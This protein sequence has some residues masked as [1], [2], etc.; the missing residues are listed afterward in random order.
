MRAGPARGLL[1]PSRA[2]ILLLATSLLLTALGGWAAARV[3][4]IY[5]KHHSF[6]FDPV[7]YQF[8]NA[9]LSRQ[10]AVDGRLATAWSEWLNNDR[11]PFRTVPLVLLA[12]KLLEEPLGYLATAL[13]ALAVFLALLGWFL[14]RRYGSP[15]YAAAGMVLF[16]SIPGLYDPHAGLGVYL[17][18]LPA[19]LWVG[20]ALICLLQWNGRSRLAWLAAFAGFASLAALSRYVAAGYLLVMAGPVLL[21]MLWRRWR[22]RGDLFQS[23]IKPLALVAAILGILAGYY[24]VAH[25]K[26]TMEFYATYGY[27]LDSEL[28]RSARATWRF[29]TSYLG[30]RYFVLLAL[31]F[32]A[33]VLCG[34]RDQ[35]GNRWLAALAWMALAHP[36]FLILVLGMGSHAQAA[37]YTLCPLFLLVLAPYPERERLSSPRVMALAAVAIILFSAWQGVS[38][39]RANMRQARVTTTLARQHKSMDR[40]LGKLLARQGDRLVWLALFDEYSW[41]PTME[42]FFNQRK[43]PLPAGQD[44]FFSVHGSVWRGN[45]PGLDRSSISR[46]VY[47]N[48]KRYVDLVLVFRDP[49]RARREL[50]NQTSAAV[51]RFV[52]QTCRNDPGWKEVFRLEVTPYGP[53]VAYRQ[54]RPARPG[55][56]EKL[57]KGEPLPGLADR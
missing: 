51:A 31:I 48:I 20:A 4:A 29:F 19:A 36:L 22:E 35:P 15:A 41:P 6:F 53:L 50:K 18:D 17:L 27:N 13:P 28:Y 10:I 34:K 23:V 30:Y 55:V 9:R 5:L 11:F 47:R 26:G 7:S 57:L 42:A 43:L 56:Y 38:S 1:S 46:L 2:A 16:A 44:Y 32:L 40:R 33:N 14:W 45:F 52:A 8:R 24:L 3:E 37:V 21:G 25:F 49:S 39:A 12:P 54:L